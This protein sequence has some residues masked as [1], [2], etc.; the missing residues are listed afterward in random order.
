[1]LSIIPIALKGD[2][3]PGQN[4]SEIITRCVKLAGLEIEEFDIL[5]I[6]QKIISK[7]EKR[8]V[9]LESIIPSNKALEI[10]KI[11]EKDP[12]IIQLILNESKKI[13][14]LSRK[15]IISQTKHGFVCANA[16]ID[17]SNV[18]KDPK[19]VLLLPENPD[20][21]ATNIRKEIFERTKKN[22]SVIISDTFGRPFRNGQTNVAIGISGMNPLRSYIGK[23]DQYGRELRVTEIAIADEIAS[24][25]E[26][27][28]GKALQVP[29]ALVRGYKYEFVVQSDNETKSNIGILVRNEK[30]DLFIK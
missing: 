9:N 15:H 10:A 12:R 8:M 1:M 13:I 29:V 16:G 24:A 21:S 7:T 14:R 3:I 30:D 11:H 18:S 6:A 2:I 17:Q 28:M 25:A 23:Y 4:L 5:V 19:Y 20:S 27:V 22:V 26:L